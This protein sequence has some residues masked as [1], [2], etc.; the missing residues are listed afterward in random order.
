[1]TDARPPAVEC[2]KRGESRRIGEGWGRLLLA[3][4]KIKQG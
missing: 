2:A 1:M 3:E 4:N